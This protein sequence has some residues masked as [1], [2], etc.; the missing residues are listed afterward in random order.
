MDYNR[1][2]SEADT[3]VAQGVERIVLRC[4]QHSRC[5]ADLATS[6]RRIGTGLLIGAASM[7]F[8]DVPLQLKNLQ[9]LFLCTLF[10]YPFSAADHTLYMI[11]QLVLL[12][13]GLVLLPQFA[14][15]DRTLMKVGVCALAI[16]SSA[17]AILRELLADQSDFLEPVKLLIN[18]STVLLFLYLGRLFDPR[19]CATWLKRCA[20]IWLVIVIGTYAYANTSTWEML[21]LLLQPDGMTSARLYELAEPLAPIFLTKNIM[22]MYV[23]A[24]FGAFLY[25]RRCAKAPVTL[26]EKSMFC[27]LIALLFSR[28]G[29][30][31]GVLLIAID[32]F[33]VRGTRTKRWAIVVIVITALVL[34]SFVAF[35]FDL[36]SQEDGATSRLEL[37]RL[38]FATWTR[39]FITGQGVHQLNASLEHLNIDNYHMFFM[40]QIAAY[41][42][43]HCVVFNLLLTIISVCALPKKV[44]WLL[45][46][47]YWLNV[48]FQTY[49]YEYGNLFL[50]CIAANG[51]KPLATR[52]P[53]QAIYAVSD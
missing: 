7:I 16:V 47:P 6:G 18:L 53:L 40:N 34:T 52:L 20:M 41:G 11:P 3:V 30:L 29:I 22:A 26:V 43:I 42:I 27:A 8:V 28:Q 33:M 1:W 45:I 48:C 17:I 15:P 50:F 9:T 21:E 2:N 5:A 13:L 4:R 36:N 49:G 10:L 32:Y 44:R 25:F 39:Y 38:F 46:A 51:V 31:S 14:A 19:I 35:A 37:W 12:G 24:I 23:V